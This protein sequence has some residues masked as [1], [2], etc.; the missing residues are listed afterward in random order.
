MSDSVIPW[1]VVCQ[2]PLSMG[3]LQARILEQVAMPSSRGSSSPRDRTQ[4]SRIAGRFFTIW[5]TKESP[6]ILEWVAYPFF[7]GTS[8]PRNWTKVSCLAGGF[9]TSWV[10][11]EAPPFLIHPSNLH[12]PRGVNRIHFC[13]GSYS[14][15]PRFPRE[16]CPGRVLCLC[17]PS[18]TESKL[19]A[20]CMTG[21]YIKR[22]SVGTW[23]SKFIWKA[24]RS[25]RWWTNVP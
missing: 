18:V 5:A 11:L 25:R 23:N 15:K 2:A 13:G 9:F 14:L 16:K 3:I 22:S 6:R 4:V 12:S 19:T 8:W 10:T 1:T 20:R 21:Q 7:R 24:R 17:P